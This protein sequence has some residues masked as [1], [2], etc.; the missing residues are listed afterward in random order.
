M[1]LSTRYIIKPLWWFNNSLKKIFNRQ[2][3]PL[4]LKQLGASEWA[5]GRLV[6]SGRLFQQSVEPSVTG[7]RERIL[8]VLLIPAGIDILCF[9]RTYKR[10]GKCWWNEIEKLIIFQ[11]NLNHIFKTGFPIRSMNEHRLNCM[12]KCKFPETARRAHRTRPSRCSILDSQRNPTTSPQSATQT[13][14]WTLC[15]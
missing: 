14:L 6:Q 9:E 15:R 2:M 4:K 1:L 10:V 3:S 8:G 13:S 11:L 12:D 7:R 5:C